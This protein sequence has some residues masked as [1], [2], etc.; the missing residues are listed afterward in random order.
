MRYKR[1]SS[2]FALLNYRDP[3]DHSKVFVHQFKGIDS[4]ENIISA[5]TVEPISRKRILLVVIKSTGQPLRVVNYT[6]ISGHQV[7]L[8]SFEQTK[9]N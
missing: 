6:W 1:E 3:A 9:S 4:I 7:V 2:D 8:S 5:F